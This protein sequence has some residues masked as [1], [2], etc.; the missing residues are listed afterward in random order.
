MIYLVG[1]CQVVEGL[2]RHNSAR[3]FCTFSEPHPASAS[4]QPGEPPVWFQTVLRLS[5]SLRYETAYSFRQ[6]N[7]WR[8]GSPQMKAL[9][10]ATT[11]TNLLGKSW[12]TSEM[13]RDTPNHGTYNMQLCSTTHHR[14]LSQ[15]KCS[16]A[17]LYNKCVLHP[18]ILG[19][20]SHWWACIWGGKTGT[21]GCHQEHKT[22]DLWWVWDTSKHILTLWYL[23][24]SLQWSAGE[25]NSR[26]VLNRKR[27]NLVRTSTVLDC[28]W[29][30]KMRQLRGQ[31]YPS[32][33]KSGS[34]LLTP[35]I[36][37]WGPLW[38]SSS[39]VDINSVG[40]SM[41]AGLSFHPQSDCLNWTSTAANSLPPHKHSY[42]CTTLIYYIFNHILS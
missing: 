35:Y 20:Y 5:K 21:Q 10:P 18:Y 4:L 26:T 24:L 17:H 32:L 6:S 36:R 37:L 28:L 13:M 7:G 39:A 1:S 2:C 34:T 9:P 38:F 29:T 25:E 40:K 3:W 11:K 27:V 19:W 33:Y 42:V 22:K 15:T 41:T 30:P 8:E 23:L 31:C 14:W 16:Y 12:N